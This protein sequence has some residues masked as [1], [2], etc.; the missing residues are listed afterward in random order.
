VSAGVQDL[1]EELRAL[2][3]RYTES[4]S[5]PFKPRCLALIDRVAVCA[6]DLHGEIPADVLG[7]LTR[8]MHAV[9]RDD[10]VGVI[11]ELEGALA[12]LESPRPELRQAARSPG[13]PPPP[14]REGRRRAK[15][16]SV[17]A[18]TGKYE[19]KFSAFIRKEFE[20]PL[21][22]FVYFDPIAGTWRTV[23]NKWRNR[24]AVPGRDLWWKLRRHLQPL[25]YWRA[26]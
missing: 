14:R 25:A 26:S 9:G 22:R 20:V 21:V 12:L 17:A 3:R 18:R 1:R 5:D 16:A 4:G 6:T 11:E 23:K 2:T 7:H 13:S 8:A 24:R 10:V 15:P 19:G